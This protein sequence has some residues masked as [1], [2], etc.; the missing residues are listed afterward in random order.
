M[1][2]AP[3]SNRLPASRLRLIGIDYGTKRVGLAMTDPLCLFAQPI[4]TFSPSEAVKQIQIIDRQEGIS[5]LIVGW[6]LTLDGQETEITARVQRYIDRLARQLPHAIIEK[7]DERY[8]SRRASAALVE[9]GVSKKARRQKGRL[10]SAA[11]ALIL[12]DYLD[13]RNE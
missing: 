6:P 12:Q 1:A 8:S 4:G 10:D 5:H 2:T 9:A 13:E 11:A 7:V 3:I